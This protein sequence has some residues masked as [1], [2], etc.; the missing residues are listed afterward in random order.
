M[1]IDRRVRESAALVEDSMFLA[2]L[3]AGDMVA[4]KAKYHTK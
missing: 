4:L 1:Q 3:S 2:R